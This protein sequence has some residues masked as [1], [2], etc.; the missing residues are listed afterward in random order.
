LIA[1]AAQLRRVAKLAHV[2]LCIDSLVTELALHDSQQARA[3]VAPRLYALGAALFFSTGGT[4]IKLSGLSSWQIA[5]FRSGLAALLLWWLVPTWRRWWSPSSLAVGVAF[6]ATLILFVTANTLTTA[7]NAIFL[8]YSAPLYLLLLGPWLLGEPNRRSDL[9]LIA[10]LAIGMLL[11]FIGQEAPSTTAPDPL[12]GNFIGACAGV[13]WAFTLLGVRWLA[14]QP[15]AVGAG[16]SA[17]IAGNVLTF[18]VCLPW[19]LPIPEATPVD[20]AVVFYLATFQIGA[21]HLCL[22]R[23][24]R[25]LGALE[26]SLLLAIEPLASGV[27]AWLVHGEIPGTMALAGCSLI[28]S[29]VLLQ[30]LRKESTRPVVM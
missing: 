2:G 17:V 21:A 20:W 3:R 18:A 30:A 10:L 25:E 16:G 15:D 1:C 4:A 23:G 14:R 8:Q 29:S 24:I 22:L 7:V 26:I 9:A 5:G 6:G 19:A 12:R 27:W 11:F 13:T 28:F